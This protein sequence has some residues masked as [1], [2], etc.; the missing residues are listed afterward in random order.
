MYS[1]RVKRDA[2]WLT[3]FVALFA[4][5]VLQAQT[6]DGSTKAFEVASVKRNTSGETRIRFETP[7]G[8]LTAVNVPLRFAIRQAYRVPESRMVGGPP[9]L[10]TDRFDILA[11][12]PADAATPDVRQML[13]VLLADRF[14][15]VLHSETRQ[16]PIYS[17]VL[18]RDDRD[19]GPNLRRSGTDCTGQTS[20][21][22]AGRVQCGVLVSQAPTSAS[23]RGGGA[24]FAEFVRL[25]GDFLDR[26]IVDDTGLTGTFDLELQFTADRGSVPGV[27][28]PGG[29]GAAANTDDIP[30]IFTALREQLGLKLD[31]RRGSAEVFVIDSVSPPS[32]K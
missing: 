9:W 11:T 12:A 30:S 28:V 2:V 27:G 17:L 29:V 16:M 32:V 6:P 8:R 20:R 24:R 19:L 21:L 18:A 25:L 4:S 31:A 5:G 14:G 22:V 10:D 23:L 13:R 7:P 26:P 15:L 1:A 3:L